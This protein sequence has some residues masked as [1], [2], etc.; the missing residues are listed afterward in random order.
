LKGFLTLFQVVD[1]DLLSAEI[2]GKIRSSLEKKGNIIGPYDLQIASIAM[3]RDFILVTNNT[4]E[5]S[6]IKSLKLE[7]WV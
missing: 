5:F 4:N 7:N 1:F 2:F 6:R 3:A